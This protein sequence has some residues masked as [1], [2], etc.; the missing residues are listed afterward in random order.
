MLPVFVEENVIRNMR[1]FHQESCH[2]VQNKQTNQP[3]NQPTNKQ[4]QEQQ[5]SPTTKA[6]FHH[7][8]HHPDPLSSHTPDCFC[9]QKW[10][11]ASG[12][13]NWQPYEDSQHGGGCLPSSLPQLLCISN[14][15][16]LLQPHKSGID[17][18]QAQSRFIS[19][20]Q[21]QFDCCIFTKWQIL[22]SPPSLVVIQVWVCWMKTFSTSSHLKG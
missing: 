14:R 3:T 21:Y 5:S 11:T 7:N 6:K 2:P 4:K 1:F 9:S 18:L 10:E 19:A 13:F 15:S 20:L 12:V 16:P 22:A 17:H 8:F